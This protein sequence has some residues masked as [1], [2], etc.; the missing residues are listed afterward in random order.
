VG[1]QLTVIPSM[2]PNQN[3]DF[4]LWVLEHLFRNIQVQKQAVFLSLS[5]N[6]SIDGTN[7]ICRRL[8]ARNCFSPILD[9][10]GLRRWSW[11][12]P[13]EFT[14][15]RSGE[16]NVPEVINLSRVRIFRLNNRGSSLQPCYHKYRDMSRNP[17]S[18]EHRR[19][20]PQIPLPVGLKQPLPASYKTA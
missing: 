2:N 7:I 5:D 18:A 17:A 15:G 3:G 6:W 13:S 19:R 11:L 20:Q 10:G 1:R 14:Y 16:A 9:F 12:L 8:C 4:C